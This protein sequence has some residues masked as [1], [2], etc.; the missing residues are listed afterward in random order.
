MAGEPDLSGQ[1]HMQ[2][3]RGVRVKTEAHNEHITVNTFC[4]AHGA[5]LFCIDGSSAIGTF[6]AFNFEMFQ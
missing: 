5:N 2:V 4:I 1:S 6:L 3:E